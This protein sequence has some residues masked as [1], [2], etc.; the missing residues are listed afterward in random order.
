MSRAIELPTPHDLSGV[1][2]FSGLP[3]SALAEVASR[4][5][6]RHLAKNARVFAQAEVAERCHALLRGR[7][8]IAQ[9][10]EDGEQLVVRF[11]GPGETFGTAALF[12][13][14]AYPAEARAVVDS[15]EVSWREVD[16]R[17]LVGRYPHIALNIT[18]VI[19]SRLQEAQQRLR[20][21]ATQRVHRRIAHALVRLAAHVAAEKGGGSAIG[22]PLSRKDVAEMCGA[23]L[24]TASRVLTAWEKAGLISSTRQ[25]VTIRKLADIRNI[26]DDRLEG[27]PAYCR[28]AIVRRQARDSK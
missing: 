14:H 11:I 6:L 13:D 24:H 2:L 1:E 8:R 16:L 12:T 26:A 21:L 23:T 17:D 18:R 10:D 15:I 7:I 22:F 3:T 25:H 5:R 19:G 9:S 4:A 28:G 27:V 20:E